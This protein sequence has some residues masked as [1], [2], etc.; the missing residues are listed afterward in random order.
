M[1]PDMAKKAKNRVLTAI[2]KVRLFPKEYQLVKPTIHIEGW[3][4]LEEKHLIL[5]IIL[6]VTH[7]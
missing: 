4:I 2:L 3:L 6:N 7:Y 5:E 1:F